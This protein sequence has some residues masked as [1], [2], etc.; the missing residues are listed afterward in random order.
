VQEQ[1]RQ[2]SPLPGAADRHHAI[3]VDDL[4]WTEDAEFDAQSRDRTGPA[5]TAL[6][7]RPGTIRLVGLILPNQE[8]N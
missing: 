4:Q 1:H 7:P 3:A 5:V 6:K 2:Q 8:Y